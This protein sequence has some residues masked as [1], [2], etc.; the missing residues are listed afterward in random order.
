M[1]NERGFTPSERKAL[2]LGRGTSFAEFV[3]TVCATPDDEANIHFR[4]Q[5]KTV[6]G[7]G[8]DMPIMADFV[9]RFENLAADFDTVAEIVGGDHKL[10]LPHRHRSKSRGSRSYV[11]FYDNRLRDLVHDRFT[12]D[13]EIFGY[14]F[15]ASDIPPPIQPRARRS[16]PGEAEEL[17]ERNRDLEQAVEMLTERNRDLEQELRSAQKQIRE[18]RRP[19]KRNRDLEQE[20]RSARKQIRELQGPKKRNRSSEREPQLTQTSLLKRV[21]R[22]WKRITHPSGER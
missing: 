19:R 22:F 1:D 9:G 2:R 11:E 4:S 21:K 6:C 14:S 13:I 20:L 17:R 15:G 7:P 5:Y 16:K 18:L 3:E 8:E 10:Q 12:E